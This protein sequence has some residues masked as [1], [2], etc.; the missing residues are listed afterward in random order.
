M[1]T[2]PKGKFAAYTNVLKGISA[3]TGTPLS[4]LIVS[5]GIIHELT[6]IVPLVGIFYTSRALGVGER[7]VNTV[8]RDT[9]TSKVSDGGSM[10]EEQSVV[11]WGKR[12]VRGWVEEGDKW[13][14]KVGR[15]YGMFGYKKKQ[16]GEVDNWDAGPE[17]HIAGDVAN[18]VVAYGATKVSHWDDI[19]GVDFDVL[20]LLVVI[21]GESW[22]V[23][24]FCTCIREGCVESRETGSDAVIW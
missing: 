18:A 6:A 5:F 15:R 16:P 7:I 17:H 19:S 11:V 20:D 4:S 10:N 8:I 9:E 22:C 3:R 13:A 1:S 23:T 2:Q 14:A 24:V 21:A 12:K